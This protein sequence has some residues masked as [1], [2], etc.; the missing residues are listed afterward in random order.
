MDDLTDALD[1][2]NR[3]A[4]LAFEKNIELEA[5]CEA[6]AGKLFYK[7]LVN[8]SKAKMHLT[9]AIK[10]SLTVLPKDLSQEP[11]HQLATK[12]L[13]EVRDELNKKEQERI[14]A[15]RKPYLDSL[16]EDLDKITAASAKGCEQF[17]VFLNENYVP[18]DKKLDLTAEKLKENALKRTMV[19]MFIPIFHP[20]KNIN[21]DRKTQIL[22]EEICKHIN[23]HVEHF[24]GKVD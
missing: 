16:K 8:F 3:A 19:R 4:K 15:E 14:D 18:Q 9:N 12:H 22:R 10:L 1:C 13:Q 24:K 5:E 23:G 17:L 20:D 7:G 11:W 2:C 6:F 21:E